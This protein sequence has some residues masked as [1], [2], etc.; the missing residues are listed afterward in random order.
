MLNLPSMPFLHP[1]FL[2]FTKTEIITVVFISLKL[3]ALESGYRCWGRRAGE[4][5]YVHRY[6][7]PAG[8]RATLPTSH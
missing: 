1:K 2:I 8:S 6:W 3:N 7:L 4:G 5:S